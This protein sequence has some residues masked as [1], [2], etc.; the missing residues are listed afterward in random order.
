MRA[1]SP[2]SYL[3]VPGNRP[4]RFAR[5][6][7][8]GADAVLVDLKMPCLLRKKLRRARLDRPVILRAQAIVDEVEDRPAS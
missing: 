2:R 6:C 8:A 5:A 3:F 4:D 1:K 7:A